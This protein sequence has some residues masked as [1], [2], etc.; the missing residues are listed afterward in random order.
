MRFSRIALSCI[1]VALL[2]APMW[3][4]PQKSGAPAAQAQEKA[5]KP[6]E[7][8]LGGPVVAINADKKEIVISR[9]GAQYPVQ[10]TATTQIFAANNPIDLSAISVGDNVTVQYTK[11][12]G[13]QREA[14]TL[15]DKSAKGA[16]SASQP[17]AEHKGKKKEHMQAEPKAEVKVK[18]VVTT[19]APVAPV[20]AE[21]K[22]P[23]AKT[24][25]SAAP[26]VVEIKQE[27]KKPEAPV[28]PKTVEVKT[29]P[30]PAPAA[31]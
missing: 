2:S 23:Q 17:K 16:A 30:A 12:A 31:K 9:N 8:V 21:V 11:T 29:S 4:A 6:A 5:A 3:A 10:V 14:I 7:K 18:P 19:E 1:C 26:K 13:G 28:A 15:E 27:P 22:A 20:K 24:E 25:V